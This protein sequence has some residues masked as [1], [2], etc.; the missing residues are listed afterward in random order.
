MINLG[1]D[2]AAWGDRDWPFALQDLFHPADNARPRGA[3]QL[4]NSSAA[5]IGGYQ[6][7]FPV[8]GVRRSHLLDPRTGRPADAVAAD[9]LT[10]NRL[11]TAHAGLEPLDDDE[12][13][14]RVS[15]A[16][17]SSIAADGRRYTG[18]GFGLLPVF[19]IRSRRPP[20]RT[21]VATGTSRHRC[22]ASPATSPLLLSSPESLHSTPLRRAGR[23]RPAST[24]GRSGIAEDG[25]R[26]QVPPAVLGGVG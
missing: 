7:G 13:L 14:A 21:A 2:L 24:H 6:R 8:G 11:A 19:P 22:S 18:S 17:G 12:L 5:S 10:A 23:G 9:S 3:F 4:C 25:I 1:G 16:D 20:V 26:P 15:G